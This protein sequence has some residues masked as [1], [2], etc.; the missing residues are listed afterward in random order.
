M[1]FRLLPKNEEADRKF[2]YC[3]EENQFMKKL[4]LVLHDYKY[5]VVSIELVL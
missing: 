2:A 1:I 3:I 5:D 4:K